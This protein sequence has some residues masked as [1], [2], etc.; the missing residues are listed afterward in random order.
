MIEVVV[1]FFIVIVIV[2]C[3]LSIMYKCTDGSMD[4]NGFSSDTCLKLGDPK[5]KDDDK[6][7]TNKDD[8]VTESPLLSGG[9]LSGSLF[10]SSLSGEEDE[11][12]YS[13]YV[14]YF[15]ISKDGVKV[16]EHELDTW[17]EVDKLDSLEVDA[18]GPGECAKICYE[19][20]EIIGHHDCN[21]FKMNSNGRKCK[22][23]WSTSE[24]GVTEDENVFRLKARRGPYTHEA[25]AEEDAVELG[26][27][28]VMFYNDKNY[29]NPG[30]LYHHNIYFKNG[31]EDGRYTFS[32]NPPKSIY[33]PEDRCVKTYGEGDNSFDNVGDGKVTEYT[34]SQ[35]DFPNYKSLEVGTFTGGFCEYLGDETNDDVVHFIR[36]PPN[37][38]NLPGNQ[39]A[40]KGDVME[41]DEA[42]ASESDKVES[43]PD[44]PLNSYKR[45]ISKIPGDEN[46]DFCG[47][48]ETE[49]GCTNTSTG[50]VCDWYSTVETAKAAG[51][52][53]AAP[54]CVGKEII[55]NFYCSVNKTEDV[56]L[57]TMRTKVIPTEMGGVQYDV[58]HQVQA[59]NWI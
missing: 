57:N 22:L 4:P 35:S 54:P 17:G 20:D 11:V 29:T 8:S 43:Y 41:G 56:C 15:T 31:A 27:T 39:W 5:K 2:L 36:S 16:E 53:A 34:M 18:N 44:D 38:Y 10:G 55:D 59:C 19:K 33:I 40:S 7:I 51:V 47:K 49:F 58:A 52:A 25:Q 50:D 13:P 42:I 14:D 12:D 23:Y 24:S 45:C 6:S 9:N 37:Y 46:T 32:S 30:L 26:G 3:I 1:L 28:N 48:Q 21:A